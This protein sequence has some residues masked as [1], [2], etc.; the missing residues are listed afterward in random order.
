MYPQDFSCPSSRTCLTSLR[1]LL[2]ESRDLGRVL[3]GVARGGEES[4]GLEGVAEVSHDH[5]G[6]ET[7]RNDEK[8]MTPLQVGKEIT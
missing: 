4:G 2:Q 5:G 7:R 8:G 6:P 1:P 3:E